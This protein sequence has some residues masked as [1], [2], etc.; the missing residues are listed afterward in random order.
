VVEDGSVSVLLAEDNLVNQKVV[1]AMLDGLA[2]L[3]VVSDGEAAVEAARTQAFDVILMDT[4]M[5][6]MDGLT[7]IRAIRSEEM[8][9]GSA[10]TPIISLTAD[11]MSQ[12]VSAAMVAGADLHV[13]KPITA[14]ALIGALRA[15][16]D[17]GSIADTDAA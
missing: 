16:L 5:P 17:G 15:V 10:R 12:Q 13:A 14:V 2:R 8:A 9:R 1:Q 6:R 3:T 11:A 4:H 7:A